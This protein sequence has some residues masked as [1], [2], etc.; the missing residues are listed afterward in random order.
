MSKFNADNFYKHINRYYRHIPTQD[1]VIIAKYDS[2]IANEE[3]IAKYHKQYIKLRTGNV[4][5]VEFDLED[6]CLS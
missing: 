3:T 2:S 6:S 1:T 5:Y 4:V